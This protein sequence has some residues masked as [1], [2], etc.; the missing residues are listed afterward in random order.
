MQDYIRLLKQNPKCPNTV[1]SFIYFMQEFTS[2]KNTLIY[3]L[4]KLES[5]E[6]NLVQELSLVRLKQMVE[7]N[8]ADKILDNNSKSLSNYSG[9]RFKMLNER[10]MLKLTNAC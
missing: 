10:M 5:M 3:E 8:N 1:I 7:G 4:A 2:Y 6:L 9:D